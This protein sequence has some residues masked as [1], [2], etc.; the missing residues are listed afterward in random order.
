MIPIDTSWSNQE[1]AVENWTI[2]LQPR[3]S[4]IN[5]AYYYNQRDRP[6]REG[7]NNNNNFWSL[8]IY[9]SSFQNILFHPPTT[10]HTNQRGPVRYNKSR[11]SPTDRDDAEYGTATTTIYSRRRKSLDR[12]SVPLLVLMLNN[13]QSRHS[14]EHDAGIGSKGKY[15]EP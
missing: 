3:T 10:R 1:R 6:K 15:A 11:P 8:Y 7:G 14:Y 9:S 2:L 13:S 12:C 4:H 5:T